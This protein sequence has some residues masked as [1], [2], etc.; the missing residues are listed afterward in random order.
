M[1][2]Y[3]WRIDQI[4]GIAGSRF[5]DFYTTHI[6]PYGSGCFRFQELVASVI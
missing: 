4:M 6:T 5:A 1:Y 3:S 2:T